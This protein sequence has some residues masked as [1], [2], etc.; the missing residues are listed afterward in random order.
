MA[1]SLN[2]GRGVSNVELSLVTWHPFT[3]ELVNDVV[4]FVFKNINIPNK[5]IKY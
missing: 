3:C 4:F 1:W 2:G 5:I